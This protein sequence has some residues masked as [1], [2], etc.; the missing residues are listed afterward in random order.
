MNHGI[1]GPVEKCRRDSN[2]GC[3]R[4][5]ECPRF[6]HREA[7]G[8]RFVVMPTSLGQ[9]PAAASGNLRIREQLLEWQGLTER[10]SAGTKSKFGG[11]PSDCSLDA[12]DAVNTGLTYLVNA[13]Y[14]DALEWLLFALEKSQDDPF[15]LFGHG[16]WLWR[17]GWFSLAADRFTRAKDGIENYPRKFRLVTFAR[18]D[19]TSVPRSYAF[20][21]I[22]PIFNP[23]ECL[24]QVTRR[25]AFVSHSLVP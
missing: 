23:A 11:V 25:Q 14:E 9:P 22:Y 17:M 3:H 8:S 12:T 2:I 1:A 19:D 10:K 7:W 6:E 18:V 24:E 15:A 5:Q 21:P 4:Q 16:L 13:F 20:N